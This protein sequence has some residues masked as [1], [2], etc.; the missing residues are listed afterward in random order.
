MEGD[1]AI[2]LRATLVEYLL[3]IAAC[4]CVRMA[5]NTLTLILSWAWMDATAAYTLSVA[6]NEDGYLNVFVPAP[7]M[8]PAGSVAPWAMIFS[9]KGMPL[10]VF[11][12]NKVS[13][14]AIVA[15]NA[16][17]PVPTSTAGTEFLVDSVHM[18]KL[19]R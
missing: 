19:W 16:S 1:G 2:R 17:V 3:S 13:L 12:A 10:N 9:V 4:T 15:N 6:S 14:L 7:A 8:M 11:L 5:L 18:A